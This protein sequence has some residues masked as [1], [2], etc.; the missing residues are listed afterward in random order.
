LPFQLRKIYRVLHELDLRA[1]EERDLALAEKILDVIK[2]LDEI[3]V[4]LYDDRAPFD[5]SGPRP[6]IFTAL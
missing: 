1:I 4:I 2:T 3:L 6:R 5:C